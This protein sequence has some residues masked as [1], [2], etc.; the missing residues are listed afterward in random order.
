[1]DGISQRQPSCIAGQLPAMPQPTIDNDLAP[2]PRFL[3]LD[4]HI[5]DAIRQLVNEADGCANM[6]FAVGGGS[7]VRLAIRQ[8][9][10]LEAIGSDDLHAAI[11]ELREKHPSVAPTLFQVIERLGSGDEPLQIDRLKALIA[12]FKAVLYEMYVLGEERRE[13]LAYLSEILQ[14]LDGPK[15]SPK[16]RPTSRL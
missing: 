8:M 6:A 13:T 4:R 16:T 7:C 1:M 5:P 2:A 11:A 15:T 3:T 9:L 10:E 12:T 14:A